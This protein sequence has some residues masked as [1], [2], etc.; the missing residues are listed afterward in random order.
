MLHVD[1]FPEREVRLA[2]RTAKTLSFV[3]PVPTSWVED[4]RVVDLGVVPFDQLDA[5]EPSELGV[6]KV[7]LERATAPSGSAPTGSSGRSTRAA[8]RRSPAGAATR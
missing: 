5:E 4:A 7:A 2:P 3:F 1:L 6:V 8:R